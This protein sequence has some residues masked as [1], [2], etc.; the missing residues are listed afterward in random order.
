[1]SS[2]PDVD[3]RRGSAV[4]RAFQRLLV[5]LGSVGSTLALFLVLP[6][7]Q[8]LTA[9][10]REVV[11]LVRV[12]AGSLPPPPP[13]VEEPPPPEEEPEEPPPELEPE[14]ELLDLS[15]LELALNP[16]VGDGPGSV[17]FSLDLAEAQSPGD[18]D[19]LFSLADLDQ[20]PRATYQPSPVLSAKVRK[21]APGTVYVLFVVDQRGRVESPTVQSST[22]PVLERPALD[23]VKQWRFE[24]GKRGGQAVRFRMRV[25]ITF[26]AS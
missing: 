9:E 2:A 3:P 12:D 20:R 24:P 13:V 7:I 19:A 22:D 18:V 10:A 25:P 23:A 21:A 5:A 17:D 11:E 1:M 15:Q 8:A 16:G 4:G 6:L 26:P 14:P